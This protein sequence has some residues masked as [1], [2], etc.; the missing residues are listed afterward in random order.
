M[1]AELATALAQEGHSV[2]VAADRGPFDSL[3]GGSGIDRRE[4]PGRGRSPLRLA[5]A[6]LLMRRTIESFDPD[7]IH[8]HNVKATGIAAVAR[9]IARGRRRPLLTTFHG[10]PRDEYRAAARILR[11]AD[12][13]ACVSDDLAAG[14]SRQGLSR[15]RMRVVRNAVPVPGPLTSEARRALDAELALGEAPVVSMVGRLVPQKAPE[16]FLEAMARVRRAVPD[17]RF[18]VVGDGPLRAR[19]QALAGRLGL[20]GRIAFTGVRKDAR[21]LIARSDL[22]VFSSEWEGMPVVALEAL[23]AG[24][25]V[26]ATD[27]EGMSELLGTGAGVVAPRDAASLAE[28]VVALIRDPG[29]RAEMGEIGRRKIA[30]EFSVERML[31]SY[32]DLYRELGAGD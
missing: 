30:E 11:M 24:T 28:A 13:V 10:V 16:R 8:A 2:A 12:A 22:I 6:S 27:V 26:V 21:D 19:A 5:R 4:V 3:L 32:R 29:R 15:E 20:D 23:A 1:L 17:C 7:V 25:P 14:L 9:R 18:L 31:G